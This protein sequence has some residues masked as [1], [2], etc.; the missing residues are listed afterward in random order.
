M[1]VVVTDGEDTASE[2]SNEDVA[3]LVMIVS[4]CI[5]NHAD[6]LTACIATRPAT[7]ASEW[8]SSV[9]AS[10]VRPHQ[11]SSSVAIRRRARLRNYYASARS[12]STWLAVAI[13]GWCSSSS[14]TQRRQVRVIRQRRS[15]S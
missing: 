10:H 2:V 4:C 9:L 5:E 3:K 8:C 1:V 6:S 7:L 11:T 13:P 15:A 14:S 12:F